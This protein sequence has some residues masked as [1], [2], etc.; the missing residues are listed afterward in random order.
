MCLV[1]HIIVPPARTHN[2]PPY[3]AYIRYLVS[4]NIQQAVMNVSGCHVFHRDKI[5][6][7]I[8]ASD[9]LPYQMPFC[10]TAP[11]LQSVAQQ[12]NVIEYWWEGITPSVITPTSASNVIG[13]CNK[14]GDI[15]FGAALVSCRIV[16]SNL[17]LYWLGTFHKRQ[18]KVY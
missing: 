5:K 3:Y 7:H 18:H 12:Q 15:I 4:I 13:Q 14:I 2:P 11:L 1:F 8:F 9:A 10:Q 16:I 17:C 6:F